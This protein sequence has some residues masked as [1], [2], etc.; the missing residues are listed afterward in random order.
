MNNENG[1]RLLDITIL[2]VEDDINIRNIIKKN[3]EN[4]GF[5]TMVA[6]DGEEGLDIFNNNHI[7]LIV[8]DL[9]LPKLDGYTFTKIVRKYNEDIP[10]IMV[11]ARSLIEDKKEA[12]EV[13]VDDYMTKPI[14]MEELILHIKSLLRRSNIL[15]S[16]KIIIGNVIIDKENFTVTKGNNVVELPQKEFLLL[17]KLLS[18]PNKI[19]TRQ[20]LMDDI[21]GSESCSFD[22]T[23]D[24]HI[25][26][27][28]R[29]FEEYPEFTIKSVRGLG[30]KAVKNEEH[31]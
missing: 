12:Y 4:N 20:E 10:I 3:L 2:I 18:Y 30:Y 22:R 24:A 11:T 29:K 14:N 25:N 1:N 27:L 31:D 6:L 13:K 19:F 28:R 15:Q 17:F 21:W 16:K 26:R 9:M 8:L 23:V 5:N 7:D